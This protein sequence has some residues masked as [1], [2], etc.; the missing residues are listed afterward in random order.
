MR[1]D[2]RHTVYLAHKVVIH[3]HEV[4][5][6][7]SPTMENSLSNTSKER[8]KILIS[9]LRGLKETGASLAGSRN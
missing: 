2:Q 7:F 6:G 4:A 5:L 3:I 8:V 1:G 9:I